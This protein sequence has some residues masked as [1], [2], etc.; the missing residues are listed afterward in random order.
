C[1]MARAGSN[2]D[3]LRVV[4]SHPM[5]LAQCHKF[6]A[7]HTWLAATVHGDTASAAQDVATSRP[8]NT[9]AIASEAAADRYGLDIL[10][11]DIQDMSENWT[12]FVVLRA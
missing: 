1:L 5:A 2:V 12:R 10:A 7:L 4:L 8:P 3:D 6:F 11:R 9:A